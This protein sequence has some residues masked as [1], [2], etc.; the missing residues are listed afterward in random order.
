MNARKPISHIILKFFIV[1]EQYFCDVRKHMSHIICYKFM[2]DAYRL[3]LTQ[4]F[5]SIC[6]LYS[7]LGLEMTA[8]QAPCINANGVLLV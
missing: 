6:P 5:L 3:L 1:I 7:R 2:L 8:L 4:R